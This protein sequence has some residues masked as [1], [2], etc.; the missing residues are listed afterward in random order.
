ML[1]PR[2]PVPQ[3]S[4]ATLSGE[5]W[6]LYEQTAENFIMLAF[7]RGLHCPICKR[8]LSDLKRKVAEFEKRGITVLALSSDTKERALQAKEEWGLDNL[9]LAYGLPIETAREWGLYISTSRGKTSLGIMEPDVFSEPG[10]F[11]VRPDMTLYASIIQTMPFARPYFSEVLSAVDYI[12][13]NDY[14]ARGQA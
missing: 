14:P 10:L 4:V 3:L 9:P 6:S 12:L 1:V 8:Y 7:Y 2:K 13:K 11:L 5:S